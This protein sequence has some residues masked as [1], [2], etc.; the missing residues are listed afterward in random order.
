MRIASQPT[1]QALDGRTFG[2]INDEHCGSQ[3]LA[4]FTCPRFG[5]Q[6]ETEA[7]A[8]RRVVGSPQTAAM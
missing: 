3:P 2:G 5:K 7:C 4:S 8:A 1:Q 6:S